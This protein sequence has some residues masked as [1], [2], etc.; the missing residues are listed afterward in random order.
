DGS[1]MAISLES[2]RERKLYRTNNHIFR[3]ALAPDGR[4]LAFFES[5]QDGKPAVLKTIPASG[6]E[7]HDLFTLHEEQPMFWGVG[8]SWTPDGRHVVIGGSRVGDNPDELW[9]IPS[10]GGEPRKLSLGIQVSQMSLHPDGRR[11]AFTS[12]TG[13][14]EVWVME[15]FLP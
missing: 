2:R 3:L 14:Q 4:R 10:T 12:R 1:I 11:V 15:N 9:V 6:G 7:S 5:P 13:G 8:I